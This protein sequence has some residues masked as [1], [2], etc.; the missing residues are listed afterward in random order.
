MW[1]RY[2]LGDIPTTWV[3]E[4]VKFAAELYPMRLAISLMVMEELIKSCFA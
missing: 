2:V 1:V 4:V 3:N